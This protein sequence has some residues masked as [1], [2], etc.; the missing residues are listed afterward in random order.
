MCRPRQLPRVSSPRILNSLDEVQARRT[1]L[2]R[3]DDHNTQK[4]KTLREKRNRKDERISRRR[5]EEDDKI[6]IALEAR[7][8]KDERIRVRRHREDDGFAKA[9]DQL[10]K[11]GLVSLM[12]GILFGVLLDS[13]C[14]CSIY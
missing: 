3:I 10:A 12:F 4:L 6:R 8:R 1:E 2:G 9:D 13:R 11:E 14:A 5:A 7:A